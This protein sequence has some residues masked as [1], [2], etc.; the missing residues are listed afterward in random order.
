MKALDLLI[1]ISNRE[2]LVRISK[3]YIFNLYKE[4]KECTVINIL[5]VSEY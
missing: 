3:A 4:V 1:S 5:F 2:F